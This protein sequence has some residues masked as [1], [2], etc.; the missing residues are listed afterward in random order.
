LLRRVNAKG[1]LPQ[2]KLRVEVVVEGNGPDPHVSHDA[3]A[4]DPRASPDD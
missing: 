4:Y 2:V 1:P 3:Q